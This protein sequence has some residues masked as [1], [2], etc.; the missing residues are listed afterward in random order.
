VKSLR[1]D[2]VNGVHAPIAK[3]KKALKFEKNQKVI[4]FLLLFD[5]GAS[6]GNHFL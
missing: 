4:Y 5:W 6:N 3:G 2:H 1:D